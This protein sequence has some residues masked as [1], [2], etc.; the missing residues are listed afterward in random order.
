[1]SAPAEELFC[2]DC[3]RNQIIVAQI[4]AD[5]L[6]DEDD[7]QYERLEADWDRYR[8]ELEGRYPQVC[9][10][11]KERVEHQLQN[12]GYMAKADHLRRIMDRS[13]QRRH[14]TETPRQIWTLRFIALAKW[15]YITSFLVQ[16]LWHVFGYMMAPEERVWDDGETSIVEKF[17]WDICASQAIWVRSVDDFCVLSPFITKLVLYAVFA[18]VLTL[19]WNPRLKD[20]TNSITGRMRGLRSLWAIRAATLS[21]RLLALYLCHNASIS[22]ETIE[23]FHY[24]HL[25]MLVFLPISLI[26]T[27]KTVRITYYTP[28]LR[29]PVDEPAD[30]PKSAGKSTR[31]TNI[32]ANTP[33]NAFETM[34][35]SFT[36]GFEEDDHAPAYPP[37][38]TLTESSYTTRGTEATTPFLSKSRR[39]DTNDMD[40]TPTQP[41]FAQRHPTVYP[42]PWVKQASIPSPTK[43]YGDHSIFPQKDPNPFHHPVPAAPKAPAQAQANP[44]NRG[45]WAPPV[46]GTTP[47]FF[48]QNHEGNG[49]VGE[50]KGLQGVGVPKNIQRNAEL[51]ASPKMKYDFYGT[52][53]E[54]GLEARLEDTFNNIFTS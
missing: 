24:T 37:S 1:M 20:K 22:R 32:P 2:A 30:R 50:P 23:G 4:T 34:P 28:S 41:R 10:H 48:N 49:G 12:A 3:Q 35:Q 19:W 29:R 39:P 13:E 27:F 54:T 53:K 36:S 42:S 46:K 6:P 44:W 33:E 14:V 26:L 31:R 17:S 8:A 38:P 9:R 7:P 16:V 18:D 52:M 40:W 5:Y 21:L 51:F 25:F 45:H 43:P 11:C 47:V 15:T